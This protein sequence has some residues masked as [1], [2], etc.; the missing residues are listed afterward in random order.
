MD[1]SAGPFASCNPHDVNNPA[2]GSGA[3]AAKQSGKKC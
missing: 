2:P 3:G 1:G